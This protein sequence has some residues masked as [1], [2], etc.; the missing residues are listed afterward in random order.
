MKDVLSFR[1]HKKKT[2]YALLQNRFYFIIN[3]IIVTCL[4][5]NNKYWLQLQ[6]IFA[7]Q[8]VFND[9]ISG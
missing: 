8:N 5:I 6:V 9:L 2:E 7:F 3:I 1:Q 4:S